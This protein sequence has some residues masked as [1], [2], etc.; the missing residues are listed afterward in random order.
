MLKDGHKRVVENLLIALNGFVIFLLCFGDLIVIPLWL[1]PV[2]RLHP[3]ILH[4]PIVIL[5]MAVVFECFR[6]NERLKK[7]KLYHDFTTYLWLIGSLSAGIAAVM[8]IFLSKEPGYEGS[9]LQWHKWFGI[10]VV[11]IASFIAWCRNRK[12]YNTKISRFVAVVS[13]VCLAVAGHFGANL[14]HGENF[15]LEPVWSPSKPRVALD[16][17]LVFQDVILPIL[18]NKCIS[19]HNPDKKKGGLLLIDEA[20]ILKGGKNGKLVIAGQPHLSLLLQRIHLSTNEKEHMPPAGKPQLTENEM[21]LLYLWV[22]GNAEFKQKVFDLPPNDSLRQFSVSQLQPG[23][24]SEEQYDFAAADEKEIKKLNNDYRFIYSMGKSSPALG[25][26]IY[27]RKNYKPKVLEELQGI[28]KQIISLYLNEV[29]VKDIDLKTINKFENLRSLN[30]NFTEVTSDGLKELET[31][32]HLKT[33]SLAGTKLNTTALN[34]IGK[35]K[36]LE[37]IVL[38]NS[39]ITNDQLK[40][41]KRKNK[42]LEIVNGVELDDKPVK[43]NGPQLKNSPFV[44]SDS[45]TLKLSHVIKDVA[46]R[47][48]LD[49]TE[50]DS[51]KSPLFRPGI[52]F[53]HNNISLKVRAFKAGWLSSE[54]VKFNFHKSTYTP[55]SV[56]YVRSGT[57]ITEYDGIKPTTLIDKEL[58]TSFFGDG[59]WLPSTEDLVANMHF[60]QP[61]ELHSITIN[62]SDSKQYM[63]GIVEV[64]GGTGKDQMRPLRIVKA[65]PGSLNSSAQIQNIECKLTVTQPVSFLK[66]IIK[67]KQKSQYF[68]IDEIFFN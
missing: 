48:T 54:T 56:S 50:P 38:S 39:G 6:F 27:E 2:G 7:E 25:V 11:I 67:P 66:V 55:D 36:N 24:G 20:S 37:K 51:A 13:I 26:N 10:A 45:M 63:P 43:L 49:G 68:F 15:V 19:C 4:F 17:A 58:G 60:A 23:E 42:N 62:C 32:K 64:W 33:L 30:L 14:T 8:G 9:T 31:L 46:M 28:G 21:Q 47:Y 1:Q 16:K 57:V 35:I 65:G 59:K 18:E 29:P 44:F 12:W 3:L 40:E 22:K 41:L 61:V 34:N 5:V 52:I 53:N